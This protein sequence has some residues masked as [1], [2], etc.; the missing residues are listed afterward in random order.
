MDTA[1]ELELYKNESKDLLLTNFTTFLSIRLISQFV[2]STTDDLE[3][4]KAMK[5]KIFSEF[6]SCIRPFS[7]RAFS[8]LNEDMS[9]PRKRFLSILEGESL[10][11]EDYQSTFNLVLREMREEFIQSYLKG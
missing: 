9:T 5:S 4:R 1:Q 3:E 8:K 10:S 6:E 7:Q 2:N 11:I